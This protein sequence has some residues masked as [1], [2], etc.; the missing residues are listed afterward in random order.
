[1]VRTLFALALAVLLGTSAVAADV[2]YKL[3]GDNTKITFVGTKPGGKHEGGFK[4]LGGTATVTDGNLETLKIEVDIETDSL[5]S[6]NDKLTGHLK[7]PDFFGVKDNPKATFK[8]TKVEKA[9][10]GYKV[11]GD[12]TMLG[13][14]KAVTFPATIAEKDGVLSLAADFK[15][16]RTQWGMNY[17][18]KGQVD[19]DVAI[20]VA[21]SAKK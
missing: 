1:M 20:K 10:K 12:L 18:A 9:E 2:S 13:K 4:K 21:L 5:Y 8:T 15:I 7:N 16:D 3:D 6:D 19:K 17:G 14:T 11:T